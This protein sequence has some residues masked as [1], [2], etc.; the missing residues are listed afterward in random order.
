MAERITLKDIADQAGVGVATV[1][2]VL[3]GRA[4]VS[5]KTAARVLQAAETLNSTLIG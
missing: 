4:P 2:R 5:A 1:D 3:N